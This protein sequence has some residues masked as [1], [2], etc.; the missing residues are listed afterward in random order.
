MVARGEPLRTLATSVALMSVRSQSVP[1]SESV[2]DG[3]VMVHV[4]G[5]TAVPGSGLAVLVTGTGYSM[6]PERAEA[7]ASMWPTRSSITSWLGA[8]GVTP[9]T[10]TSMRTTST[11]ASAFVPSAEVVGGL[12]RFSLPFALG[13]SPTLICARYWAV[14]AAAGGIEIW[15][16]ILSG[17]RMSWVF[18]IVW[19]A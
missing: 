4:N 6:P 9:G 10:T 14:P 18:R 7:L 8:P 5:L 13:A 19:M 1:A 16:G 11:A 17:P 12:G 2:A 15:V 3:M